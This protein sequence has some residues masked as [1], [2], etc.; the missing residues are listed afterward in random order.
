MFRFTEKC[1]VLFVCFFLSLIY[2]L[3]LILSKGFHFFFVQKNQIASYCLWMFYCLYSVSLSLGAQVLNYKKVL[4]CK[5]CVCLRMRGGR[6]FVGKEWKAQQIRARPDSIWGTSPCTQYG[7]SR[8]Q[9]KLKLAILYTII[10]TCLD[11]FSFDSCLCCILYILL[12]ILSS[13]N[14]T[15]GITS[16][17][18]L[19]KHDWTL[20][21]CVNE[22]ELFGWLSLYFGHSVKEMETIF[23]CQTMK[24]NSQCIHA[25]DIVI[26]SCCLDSMYGH[27]LWLCW[28]QLYQHLIKVL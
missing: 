23:A 6:P 11:F 2:L 19:I 3:G 1:S 28:N 17:L 4:I 25:F 22:T 16:N 7:I 12:T 9:V 15:C 14:N 24:H 18:Q 27:W 26:T 21:V 8:P 13:C 10:Q 20:F 5:C